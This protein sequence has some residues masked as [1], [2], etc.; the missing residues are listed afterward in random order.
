MMHDTLLPPLEPYE[1]RAQSLIAHPGTGNIVR[2][3]QSTWGRGGR[4]YRGVGWAVAVVAIPAG[5]W[6]GGGWG[7]SCK[8]C[9][10]AEP[11][12][13]SPSL[14]AGSVYVWLSSP[15]SRDGSLRSEARS[16][17]G[18]RPLAGRAGGARRASADAGRATS[19]RIPAATG[20]AQPRGPRR[21]RV[22]RLCGCATATRL[23][24]EFSR[25]PPAA[26]GKPAVRFV[27]LD[28][29]GGGCRLKEMRISRKRRRPPIPDID[30]P[31]RHRF[32]RPFRLSSGF[33]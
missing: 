20:A 4:G 21:L 9:S 1:A 25:A 8:C 14:F 3:L 11:T 5:A 29:M 22:R 24:I 13:L 28:E 6:N 17:S 7:D 26:R 27:M 16:V 18:C 31:D 12:L 10:S 33:D 19:S 2:L 15:R 23:L 30:S 32:R